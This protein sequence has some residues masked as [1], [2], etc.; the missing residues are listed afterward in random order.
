VV[1]PRFFAG[2]VSGLHTVLSGAYIEF[3]PSIEPAD[4]VY[5]FTGLEDPPVLQADVPGVEFRLVS[6]RLGSLSLGSPILF[7]DQTVGEI[8]G[9]DVAELAESVTIHA[10]VRA[11]FDQYVRDSTRFWNASGVSL[12]LG[13]EGLHVQ[14]ES[15]RA[16]VLGGIAFDTPPKGATASRSPPG[17]EFT[18]YPTREAADAALYIRS[19]PLVAI[20]TGSV[21]GLAAGSEVRLRG[22]KVGEVESVRLEYNATHDNVVAVARFYVEP[23]RIAHMPTPGDVSVRARLAQ[24]I[25]RGLKVRI[26]YGNVVTGSKVLTLDLFANDTPGEI[27]ARDG[28]IVI[29]TIDS[30]GDMMATMSYVMDQLASMPFAQIGQN[31]SETLAGTS[32]LTNDPHAQALARVLKAATE[33]TQ[34]LATNLNKGVEPV[35]Q[36]LPAIARHLD[37][38][39]TRADKLMAS[40]E[41]GYGANS[42]LNRDTTRLLTQLAD[43]ARSIRVLA[44]LLTRHPEALI[45][46]RTGQ[47]P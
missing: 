38:T 9:W 18:L 16:L 4:A 12:A 20:F 3:K 10:F 47:G 32:A 7:R 22:L 25:H 40:I 6:P 2:S 37:E 11:P 45:R 30:S 23:S 13:N 14:L 5:A 28:A 21:A 41:A 8:L 24:L 27:S 1:K 17:H 15:L 33:A 36:R 31:L 46:G 35:A 26:D 34:S 43:T 29:P 44:D 42:Q 39:I 19:P